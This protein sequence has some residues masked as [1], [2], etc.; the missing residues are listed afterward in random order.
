MPLHPSA[1]TSSAI[2]PTPVNIG[3]RVIEG[4]ALNTV[5]LGGINGGASN[6]PKHVNLPRH[7]LQMFRV[8][9]GSYSAEVVDFKSSGDLPNEPLVGKAMCPHLSALDNEDAIPRFMDVPG[10]QPAP[11]FGRLNPLKQSLQWGT[12]SSHRT[13]LRCHATGDERLA[14]ASFSSNYSEGR[15]RWH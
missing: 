10:P 4:V 5:G 9:T 6:P 8:H 13:T 1:S 15:G 11:L 14:V 2:S 7:W 3:V 12:L